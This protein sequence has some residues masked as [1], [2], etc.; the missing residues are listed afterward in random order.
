MPYGGAIKSFTTHGQMAGGLLAARVRVSSLPARGRRIRAWRR[1]LADGDTDHGPAREKS[2]RRTLAGV[3][4]AD[5][6]RLADV[7]LMTVSR[8][9]NGKANV[10]QQT[11]ER[12]QAAIEALNY[13]PS[14][15]A[16]SLAAAS[17]I[18][19]GLLYS[20]PSAGYLN[21]FLVGSLDQ[22]NRENVQLV[23]Q[24]CDSAQRRLET[25]RR[26]IEGGIDGVILPPPLCDVA[27][28]HGLLVDAGVPAVAVASGRPPIAL[29]SVNIDDRAAA[30]AMTGHLVSL[31][32]RRIGFVAGNPDQTAS[33]LRLYGYLDALGDAGLASDSDLIAEGLFT[34]R[35]GLEAAGALM[36]LRQPP[37]ALFASNDDMAAAAVSVAHRMGL[38]VPGDLSV[39]GF[40]DAPQATAIWPELT[41]IRQPIAEMSRAAVQLLIEDVRARR[42]GHRSLPRHRQMGFELVRRESDTAPGGR[43]KA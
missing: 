43:A 6:A 21:E 31:G 41:T 29:S 23:V 33:A 12:V 10:R 30:R 17:E 5:V 4:I 8:V 35:S 15:A 19:I 36:G 16:R 24:L 38:D 27:D 32:H 9:L 11:R 28:L 20:N 37:T 7:S 25:V 18:R 39:V 13:S 1:T 40:D 3:T 14:A 34:Y 2:S 22:A 26:L 42:E